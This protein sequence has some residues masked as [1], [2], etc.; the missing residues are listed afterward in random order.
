MRLNIYNKS[1]WF[2]LVELIVVITILAVLWTVAFVSFQDYV[3]NS[4]DSKR[5]TDIK[6]IEKALELSKLQT[7]V[8]PN[9]GASKNITFSWATA[10]KQ[11]E[12]N[13]DVVRVVRNFREAPK[14]PLVDSFYAYSVTKNQGE[15]QLGW[16]LEDTDYGTSANGKLAGAYVKGNYNG[17]I[18]KVST[19][20]TTYVLA[21]PSILT[22]DLNETDLLD[23]ITAKKLV[24][25]GHQNLPASY[26]GT[27]YDL[28]W[29][30]D[31]S[32]TSIV[33][34][35]WDLASVD[36]T[37]LVD[38]LQTIYTWSVIAD[39]PDI[40]VIFSEDKDLAADVVLW[41]KPWTSSTSSTSTPSG[42]SSMVCPQGYI[43]I[44]WNSDFWTSE[45]CIMQYEAKN[46]WTTNC[47]WSACPVSQKDLTFWTGVNIWEAAA[48][49]LSLGDG[50]HLVTNNEWMTVAR[51]IEVNPLNWADGTIGSTVASGWGLFRWNSNLNDSATCNHG[52]FLDWNTVGNNCLLTN[53]THTNRN[54]RMHILDNGSEIWDLA[55]N[56]NEFVNG[57]NDITSTTALVTSGQMCSGLSYASIRSWFW[58]DGRETCVFSNNASMNY[59]KENYWPSWDYNGLNWV[60]TIYSHDRDSH[61]GLYRGWEVYGGINGGIYYINARSSI[62]DNWVG[63]WFRCAYVENN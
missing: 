34:Y 13:N 3:W 42:G 52:V 56:L 18:V 33:A 47:W 46:D 17:K 31:F 49:C 55:W 51:N 59:N 12:F 24:Y 58:N 45:F 1:R 4:R 35:Q 25:K 6:N 39:E 29:G 14:D 16:V 43:K 57:N 53:S 40:E 10:W 5:T 28:D 11:G 50:Y 15:Y 61:R 8:Y 37:T 19:G 23:I 9:A 44:P 32:P 62:Y 27:V 36:N 38:N 30:F 54:K 20:S 41:K 63:L 7:G 21:A 2:T 22:S 26:T 48:A 60:W